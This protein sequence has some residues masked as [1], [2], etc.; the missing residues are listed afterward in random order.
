M[1]TFVF[2]KIINEGCTDN[3]EKSEVLKNS[4]F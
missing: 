4:L 3:G 1:K 2:L